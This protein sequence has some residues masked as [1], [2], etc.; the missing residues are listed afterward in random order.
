MQVANRLSSAHR[1]RQIAVWKFLYEVFIESE[2][3]M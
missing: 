2:K 3:Q 1:K